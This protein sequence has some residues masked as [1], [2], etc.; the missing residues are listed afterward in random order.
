MTATTT[1][2]PE[3][4]PAQST[5]PTKSWAQRAPTAAA[6]ATATKAL[7]T[8]AFTL[9]GED[10]ERL[11][12]RTDSVLII[13]GGVIVYERY[14]RGFS[15]TNKHLA[16]SVTKSLTHAA[17]GVAVRDGKLSPTDSICKTITDL[18]QSQCAVTVD[19]L[20]KMSSGLDWSEGYED[21]E[22]LQHSSVLAGLY[23][24]AYR[25]LGRFNARHAFRDPPGQSFHYSSGDTATLALVLRVAMGP[26]PN[27]NFYKAAVFDP[28]GAKDVTVEQDGSGTAVGGSYWYATP[29]DA[30]RFGYL[31]LNDGCW[32]GTRI[33]P[34]GWV[35]DATVPNDA[36]L[37]K[38]VK[39]DPDDVYGRLWWL[40]RAVPAVGIPPPFPDAPDDLFA[41]RGHWG[42]SII[43][44]PSHDTVIV[45]FADDRD[46]KA[47]SFNTFASLAVA[48]ADAAGEDAA[49]DNGS[50]P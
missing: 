50:Q 21:D 30:A 47:F 36:F 32:N 28:I 35:K 18:P 14:A 44:V 20:L 40:N 13:R 33:L 48:V 41:A 38:R 17:A 29:H 1:A 37:K 19:D 4:C 3:T 39:A 46:P 26:L 45:R 5:W 31:Y 43:V 24:S 9:K 25:D 12:I 7:E 42:Q 10:S 22:S 2:T 6:Y 34:P 16:W 23:G 15:A 49:A 27:N 11:G 8:Y